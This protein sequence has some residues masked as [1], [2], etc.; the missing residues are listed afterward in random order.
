MLEVK[1]VND[2]LLKSLQISGENQVALKSLDDNGF[3][4]IF[5]IV[6]KP[7][8]EFCCSLKGVSEETSQ[9]IHMAACKRVEALDSIHR[10]LRSRNEPVM[11]AIPKLGIAPLST[12]L[13]AAAQR[14][15]GSDADLEVL[16][17]ERSS[18]GYAEVTSIQSLFSP[19]RYL[20][21]LYKV[22]KGLHP[23]S[24]P[25]HIEQR[26]PD[27]KDL[28]LDETNLVKEVSTLDILNE[29][30][31]KGMQATTGANLQTLETIYYPMTLPY[32]DNLVQIRSVLAT[33]EMSMQQVWDALRDTQAIL[34]S[35]LSQQ[36]L[37]KTQTGEQAVSPAMREQLE[38]APKLY[39][40]LIARSVDKTIIQKHFNLRSPDD[41]CS[42][43]EAVDVFAEHLGLT[44]NQLID[45]T[46]QVNSDSASYT[47]AQRGC[48]FKY[49]SSF[50]GAAFTHEYGQ[51][52]ISTLPASSAEPLPLAVLLVNGQHI[53]NLASG[54][55][56]IAVSFCDRS[57]RLARLQKLVGLEFH[58]LDW[59]IYNANQTLYTI[60]SKPPYTAL[61]L[62]PPVLGVIAEYKRLS[63]IYG[64]SSEEFCCF[65]G[66]M[67][68]YARQFE[69]SLYQKL[70][71]SATDET[72]IPLD[73]ILNFDPNVH[74]VYISIICGALKVTSDELY[75]MAKLAFNQINPVAVKMTSASYAQLYRLAM[76]PRMFGLSFT[77]ANA[78]W[79]LLNP[80]NDTAKRVGGKA[81]LDTL[82]VIRQTETVLSWMIDNQLDI[83]TAQS[84]TTTLYS[85]TFTPELH[86]FTY[87]LYTSLIND[88][89]SFE[90][91]LHQAIAPVF[92]SKPNV[93]SKLLQWQDSFFRTADGTKAYGLS[94][95]WADVQN[96]HGAAPE[97]EVSKATANVAR[98]CQGMAQYALIAQW[99]DL[100]EQDL[101]LIVDKAATFE[102][103]DISGTTENLAPG[104]CTAVTFT[105]SE[106]PGNAFSAANVVLHNGTLGAISGTGTTRKATVTSNATNIISNGGFT[107]GATGWSTSGTVF[108]HG[109]GHMTFESGGSVNGVIQQNVA[110]V[111]GQLYVV[112]FWLR[113]HN[114]TY[115]ACKATVQALDGTRVLGSLV[116]TA[117]T[118]GATVKFTFI[119][120]SATTTI[121]LM[122]TKDDPSNE[123][124]FDDF[125][126]ARVPTVT[127]R[128]SAF[129]DSAAKPSL[130][131]LLRVAR[132]KQWLLRA[133]V[134]ASEAIGY[135]EKANQPG[136]TNANALDA[137]AA[138]HGWDSK[139]TILMNSALVN[140]DIY[141]DFPKCFDDVYRLETW[142]HTGAQLNVGS[143]CVAQLFEMSKPTVEAENTDLINRVAEQLAAAMQ[144]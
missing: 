55:N 76:I 126:V 66:D 78:L 127:V 137:L 14:S 56:E 39:E 106:D 132:L 49:G 124:Y 141:P 41:I 32:H 51:M 47:D 107:G 80:G 31:K 13:Q 28:V 60:S 46:G 30:L 136:Q 140:Q 75:L 90:Q 5:D 48:F 58:R 26:R 94:D 88:G 85:S 17:P 59:L 57:E 119:A 142:M 19:G 64:V 18:D 67:T 44:F 120:S 62:T 115:P 61:V 35:P 74:S 118:R 1:R 72:T 10:T 134:P 91:K 79:E 109:N 54:Q 6:Q 3:N 135:F 89:A 105:F 81:T 53:V 133:V 15:L 52:Y 27:I 4:S 25:L 92:K 82:D 21:E 77:E 113:G 143:N 36:V 100:S 34:F 12:E 69:Q 83:P 71:T 123:Y 7:L 139:Q 102:L 68:T 45:M 11:Q 50:T 20:V 70:F 122:E 73:A 33:F 42:Q 130:P 114:D 125:V 101:D 129:M 2:T 112:Q 121:K 24:S 29:T 9:M 40:L 93:M 38:M 37:A 144:H 43:L 138:I 131:L 16:I 103:V 95:F 65:I 128:N 117:N 87:N 96:V 22:A 63:A 111:A 99:A 23:Q 86:N 104:S 97:V 110:T 98:Y 8:E 84:M 116:T 108:L